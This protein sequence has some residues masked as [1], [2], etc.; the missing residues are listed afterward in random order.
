[1]VGFPPEVVR[2]LVAQGHLGAK[3]GRGFQEYPPER[4]AERQTRRDTLFLELVKLLYPDS[5]KVGVIAGF[6]NPEVETLR[7]W[8][9]VR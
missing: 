4:L 6:T 1:M 8:V 7:G 5:G 3:T 9:D 2:Q